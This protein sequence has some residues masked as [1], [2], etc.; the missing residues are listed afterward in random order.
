MSTGAHVKNPHKDRAMKNLRTIAVKVSKERHRLLSDS[1][2]DATHRARVLNEMSAGATKLAEGIARDYFQ[3]VTAER[4]Q[5]RASWESPGQHSPADFRRCLL[6]C[7]QLDDAGMERYAEVAARAQDG[8]ALRAVACSAARRL[9][10]DPLMKLR[11]AT[12]LV[13]RDSVRPQPATGAA[14]IVAKYAANDPAWGAAV[15][16]HGEHMRHIAVE[17]DRE[18]WDA[19]YFA[20]NPGDRPL[21]EPEPEPGAVP[22]PL[23]PL[24]P[25]K[26]VSALNGAEL[27]VEALGA[28]EAAPAPAA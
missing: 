11:P 3:R 25:A 19:A 28:L 15:V 7:D 6:E 9:M 4:D 23:A 21:A 10:G 14:A 27:L 12:D 8:V 26:P 1:G 20:A 16:A 2:I 18:V 17:F 22:P 5:L 24:V 13:A